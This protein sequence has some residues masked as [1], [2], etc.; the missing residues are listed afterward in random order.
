MLMLVRL[1]SSSGYFFV[2]VLSNQHCEVIS[3]WL[4]AQKKAQYLP[5]NQSLVT[6]LQ[7]YH[8]IDTKVIG[9]N[10]INFPWKMV[11]IERRHASYNMW[12]FNLDM[13]HFYHTFIRVK[14]AC[15]SLFW[16]VTILLCKWLYTYLLKAL[17]NV[18]DR[19]NKTLLICSIPFTHTN[20]CNTS[21]CFNFI[22][23]IPCSIVKSICNSFSFIWDNKKACESNLNIRYFTPWQEK[24]F[25]ITNDLSPSNVKKA[26]WGKPIHSLSTGDH[27]FNWWL[28]MKKNRRFLKHWRLFKRWYLLMGGVWLYIF[29]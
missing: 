23:H 18:H 17:Y 15:G 10:E 26:R 21:Y 6:W 25:I 5:W 1:T 7:K 8:S 22:Y 16:Y 29:T 19:I 20:T 3:F 27:I 24:F 2:Q 14:I 13:W 4:S 9:I 11:I 28:V 12:R